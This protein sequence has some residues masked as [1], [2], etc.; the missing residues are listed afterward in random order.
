MFDYCEAEENIE[1]YDWYEYYDT[2]YDYWFIGTSVLILVF[3]LNYSVFLSFY[4]M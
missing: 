1:D 4:V 3:I 2:A